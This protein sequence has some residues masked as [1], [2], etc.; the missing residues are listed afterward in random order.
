ME[1]TSKELQAVFISRYIENGWYVIAGIGAGIQRA[2]V[3]LAHLTH[4]PDLKIVMSDYFVDFLGQT[5]IG[6]FRSYTDTGL[7]KNANY[8]FPPELRYE[9]TSRIDLMFVG[10]I[11]IDRFGNTNLI[12]I[13][14][15]FAKLKLRG[16]GSIGAPS[17]TSLVKRYIIF[18]NSHN[19]RTFVEKCDFLSTVGWDK[20]GEDAR[21]RLGLPGGGPQF[22]ITPLCIMDFTEQSKELRLKYLMPNASLES[23]IE[24]T[25]FS[26]VLPERVE[27]IPEPTEVELEVLRNRIDP[28]GILRQ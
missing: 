8:M 22:V 25:G 23:V 4:C 24:N 17:M 11:Q 20:G 3:I 18:T 12:G 10:G 26:L 28:S 15:N 14:S 19:K 16:A 9:T 21:R 7:K 2:G 1:A 27:K 13:G 6:D 5:E